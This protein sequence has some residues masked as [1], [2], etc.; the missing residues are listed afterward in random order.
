MTFGNNDCRYHDNAPPEAEKNEFYSFI[1]NLWF[2][3]HTPNRPFATA[4]KET[5]M[6]GGYYRADISDD[7]SILELNTMAYNKDAL[8]ELIGQSATDQMAWL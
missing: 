4:A 3:N 7:V 5:M 8:P 1:Y 2:V 6:N